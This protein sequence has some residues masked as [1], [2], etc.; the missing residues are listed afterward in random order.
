MRRTPVPTRRGE[1]GQV[2]GIEAIPFGLLVFVSGALLIVNAWGVVDTKFAA[3]A[4]ARHA[5]RH[6]AEQAGT[7]LPAAV[8]AEAE[9]IA[10]ETFADHGRPQPVTIELSPADSALVRCQRVTVTVRAAVPALRVPFVGG[11]GEA[12]EVVAHHSELVDPGRS[13]VGGDASCIQ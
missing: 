13:G 3:D 9:A 12:F 7:D 5:V 4:A 2:A 8:V 10:A 11:F 6:V 1:R